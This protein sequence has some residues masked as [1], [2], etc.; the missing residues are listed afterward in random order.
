MQ[1]ASITSTF[2]CWVYS[3]LNTSLR[4]RP[5]TSP[6]LPNICIKVDPKKRWVPCICIYI[7]IL[8][9]YIYIYWPQSLEIVHPLKTMRKEDDPLLL[10]SG[11]FF[12]GELAVKLRGGYDPCYIMRSIQAW[13]F[14][15]SAAR[16]KPFPPSESENSY[17]ISPSQK[18][19]QKCYT[20]KTHTLEIWLM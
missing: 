11:M 5:R 19:H 9:I 7:Y 20:P 10:A 6:S 4:S 16:L 2:L 15:F 3:P 14:A 18:L 12:R 13:G 17:R 8:C 1:A